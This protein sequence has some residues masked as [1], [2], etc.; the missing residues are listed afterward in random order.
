MQTGDAGKVSLGQL[1]VLLCLSR[2]FTVMTYTPEAQPVTYGGVSLLSTLLSGVLQMGVLT[3]GIRLSKSPTGVSPMILG[4]RGNPLLY[5]LLGSCYW[6]LSMGVCLY[7]TVSFTYFIISNFYDFA[8]WWVVILCLTLAAGVA[9]RQGLEAICRS[10]A[11]MGVLLL[12]MLAV[13]VIGLLDQLSWLN[14][15]W[16][17][18]TPYQEGLAVYRGFAMNFEMAAF[19]L[20]LPWVRQYE[21]P[22]GRQW[23]AWTTLLTLGIQLLLEL[24]VGSYA[25][26]KRFPLF[27]LV[28]TTRFVVLSRLDSVFMGIWVVLGFYKLAVF[29][30]VAVSLFAAMGYRPVR[31]RDIWIH[32][33]LAAVLSLV[34]MGRSGL[35][36]ALYAAVGAGALTVMGVL[37]LP[38]VGWV[39]TRKERLSKDKKNS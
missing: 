39:L 7:T 29:L 2:M 28:T 12:A 5:R 37:V 1:M 20:L 21:P 4:Q 33:G 9:L 27:T 23:I 17:G 34:S 25:R 18:L 10:A 19:L 3:L 38:L 30:K 6:L 11:V 22:R 26:D 36:F 14:L 8:Y 16:P 13:A 35:G 15:S 31:H 24:A 32:S